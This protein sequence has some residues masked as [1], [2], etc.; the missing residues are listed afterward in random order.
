MRFQFPPS[1]VTSIIGKGD[2]ASGTSAETLPAQAAR[3]LIFLYQ[4]KVS[5]RIGPLCRYLPSCSKYTDE[6]IHRHGLW[7][8]GWMGVARICR[9][10]PGSGGY[11]PVPFALP[12]DA[13]PFTPWRYGSWHRPFS[14]NAVL[15]KNNLADDTLERAII[16]SSKP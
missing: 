10:R 5:A 6:A 2:R 4:L 1:A 9:C 8:G 14:C 3:G 15:T 11:D 12:N 16:S 7:A 13:L